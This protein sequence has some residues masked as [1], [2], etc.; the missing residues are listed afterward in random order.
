MLLT[1]VLVSNFYIRCYILG[2]WC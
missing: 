2:S 1:Y